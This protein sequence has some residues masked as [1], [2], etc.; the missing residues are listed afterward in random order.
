MSFIVAFLIVIPILL[1][2]YL[3]DVNGTSNQLKN[4]KLLVDLNSSMSVCMQDLKIA[5]A[6]SGVGYGE[7]AARRGI[8]G[9]VVLLLGFLV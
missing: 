6:K 4:K 2:V 8:P 1:A 5:Y 3:D 9:P 7:R